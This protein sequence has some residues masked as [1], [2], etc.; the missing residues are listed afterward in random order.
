[1][2]FKK[3]LDLNGKKALVTGAARG[4]GRSCV[5]A[6]CETG[7]FVTLSDINID[8]LKSTYTDLKNKKFDVEMVK[9]DVTDTISLNNFTSKSDPYHILVCNAGIVNWVDAVD[10]TDECW[11]NLLNVNLSG[12]FRCC[13]AFGRKMIEN[14]GGSIINIGSMSGII[15]NTPQSQSH[16][17]TSKAAVHQLTKSLAVEWAQSGVRVNSVAPTYIET[18]LLNQSPEVQ[19]YIEKWKAQTPMKRLGQ[20]GEVASVVQFLA[21]EASSLITGSI[22]NVDGGFTAV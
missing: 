21:S 7:A 19:K 16:Y 10:M 12:V 2:N 4:I 17:N 15:V 6:L 9:L 20:P 13:R 1:M 8:L 18:D 11:N 5:E 3:K 14:G 22:I